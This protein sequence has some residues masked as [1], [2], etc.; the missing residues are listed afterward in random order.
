MLVAVMLMMIVA[1]LVSVA[2]ALMVVSRQSTPTIAFELVDAG[3]GTPVCPG[4]M[5]TATTRIKVSRVPA[6]VI[7]YDSWWSY[8]LGYNLVLGD[9]AHYS[10]VTAPEDFARV[11]SIEVPDIPAGRYQYRRL[12]QDDGAPLAAINVDVVVRE[13]CK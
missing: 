5:I 8:R 7:I 10:V 4:D 1:A 13:G 3:P 9:H 6:L 11:F 12:A 2:S